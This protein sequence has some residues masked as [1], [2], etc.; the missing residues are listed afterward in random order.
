MR[1][2]KKVTIP[3]FETPFSGMANNRKVTYEELVRA[4]KPGIIIYSG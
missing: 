3:E 1:S 2:L 4:I